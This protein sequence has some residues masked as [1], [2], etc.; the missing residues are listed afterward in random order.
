MAEL[1]RVRPAP[2]P[3][4]DERLLRAEPWKRWMVGASFRTQ[5]FTTATP[6]SILIARRLFLLGWYPELFRASSPARLRQDTC[7][8]TL[9]AINFM[10]SSR[11]RDVT[12]PPA[13]P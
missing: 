13:Y 8:T 1:D 4:D 9:P 6:A 5:N 11:S 3:L 10:G 12:L 2:V 7:G